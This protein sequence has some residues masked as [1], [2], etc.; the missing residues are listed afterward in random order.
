MGPAQLGSAGYRAIAF[1]ARGHGDSEWASD[2]RYGQ[3]AMIEDVVSLL[4]ALGNERPALVGASMGGG[5][6]LVAE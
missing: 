6:S 1:D 3:D 2:G 5:T 4:A